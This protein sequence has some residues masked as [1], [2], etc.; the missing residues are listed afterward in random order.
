MK[1]IQKAFKE[2]T[3]I[4]NQVKGFLKTLPPLRQRSFIASQSLDYG[5]RNGFEK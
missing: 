3:E 4:L 5:S 1:G 2:D